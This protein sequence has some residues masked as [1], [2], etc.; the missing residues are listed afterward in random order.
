MYFCVSI[1]YWETGTSTLKKIYT[2]SYKVILIFGKKINKIQAQWTHNNKW[3]SCY[4]R[5]A[6]KNCFFI[7]FVI[8][9]YIMFELC[10]KY[11]IQSNEMFNVWFFLLCVCVYTH[12]HWLYKQ[13]KDTEDTYTITSLK[14]KNDAFILKI[15]QEVK[16]YG[17]FNI[18]NI[19]MFNGHHWHFLKF[20][21]I[22]K[23]LPN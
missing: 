7:M 10:N 17:C 3:L 20:N 1:I 13:T 15:Y 2:Y 23:S 4:I 9:V 21:L 8:V 6:M 5:N 16:S 22:I 12:K 19:K 11:R 14:S 18:Y